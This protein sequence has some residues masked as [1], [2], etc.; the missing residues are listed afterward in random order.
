MCYDIDIIPPTQ[1]LTYSNEGKTFPSKI[2]KTEYEIIDQPIKNNNTKTLSFKFRISF[3][4]LM[5]RVWKVS[6][7]TFMLTSVKLFIN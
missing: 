2:L 1:F 3:F 6:I 7:F 5:Q 4:I